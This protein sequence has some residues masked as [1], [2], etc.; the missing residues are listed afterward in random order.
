MSQKHVGPDRANLL[1]IAKA[2][3]SPISRRGLLELAGWSGLAALASGVTGCAGKMCDCASNGK[4]I[5]QIKGDPQQAGFAPGYPQVTSDEGSAAVEQFMQQLNIQ[6]FPASKIHSVG[7]MTSPKKEQKQFIEVLILP[8]HDKPHLPE[9]FTY[10]YPEKTPV[11]VPVV[12]EFR[13]MAEANVRIGHTAR[14]VNSNNNMQN[15]TAGWIIY[16]N[17]RVAVV[18]CHHALCANGNNSLVGTQDVELSGVVN[19]KLYCFERLNLDG[20]PPDNLWDLA[21]ARFN[22]ASDAEGWYRRCDDGNYPGYSYPVALT[23][24]TPNGQPTT[25]QL[26]H[27]VGAATPIC[28]E[29]TLNGVGISCT[30]TLPAGTANFRD[31]LRFTRMT[32]PGDSG[33]IIVRNSDNTVSGLHFAASQGGTYSLSNPLFKIPWTRDM[34]S[35]YTLPNGDPIPRYNCVPASPGRCC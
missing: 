20:T 10:N 6:L 14:G 13:P 25:G 23:P 30:V 3:R 9:T 28:D 24:N 19:A 34:S 22:N 29:G 17:A 1:R 5:P 11:T 32:N 26:Y 2:V 12:H 4:V 27:K 8:G 21:I 33:A 15:C 35:N 31:A 7:L 18:S 16:Y